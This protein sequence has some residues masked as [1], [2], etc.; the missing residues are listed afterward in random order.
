MKNFVEDILKESKS[1]FYSFEENLEAAIRTEKEI[2]AEHQKIFSLGK[3][4]KL[5]EK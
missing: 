3:T 5:Y 2:G 4:T 1:Y